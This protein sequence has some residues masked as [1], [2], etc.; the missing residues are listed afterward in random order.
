MIRLI[1]VPRNGNQAEN[2]PVFQRT[3]KSG[4]PAANCH[5]ANE[6]LRLTIGPPHRRSFDPSYSTAKQ[7]SR[8]K[9]MFLHKF[10]GSRQNDR[11]V[12][13]LIKFHCG[14]L[15]A[16]AVHL[17]GDFNDWN[18]LSHPMHR[19]ADGSW[20]LQLPLT[21]GYHPYQFMVDGEPILD[22]TAIGAPFIERMERV[23]LI[24]IS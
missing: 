1:N 3:D 19:Q 15:Q 7:S 4:E 11:P 6:N 10:N 22:P 17:A 21:R 8:K 23:S 20:M 2:D 5:R 16:H 9:N 18:P 14:A 24:A 13:E 12:S